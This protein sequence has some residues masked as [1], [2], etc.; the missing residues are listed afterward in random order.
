M[1]RL[2]QILALCA[3]FFTTTLTTACGGDEDA[4]RGATLTFLCIGSH[5]NPVVEHLDG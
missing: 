4:S 1:S 3:L 2:F 5:E